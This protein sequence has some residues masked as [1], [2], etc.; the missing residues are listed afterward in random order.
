MLMS[1]NV[2]V[3]EGRKK[4][5][6]RGEFKVTH[7]RSTP[8]FIN[9]ATI[10]LNLKATYTSLT[11]PSPIFQYTASRDNLTVNPSSAGGLR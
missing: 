10:I 4:V 1:L 7:K 8:R 9:A 3:T 2:R 6:E 5:G 11:C